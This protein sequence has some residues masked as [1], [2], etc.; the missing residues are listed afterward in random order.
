MRHMTEKDR[1]YIEFAL[2]KKIP[3]KEIAEDLGFSRVAIYEE[4]KKGKTV[5]RNSKTWNDEIVY[6]S[7]VG[8][9]KHDEAM[10]NTG[11]PCKLSPDAPELKEVIDLI[12]NQKYSPEAATYRTKQ[13]YVCVKTI[14][15]Y[16]HK[17]HLIGVTVNHLPY[18]V[19]KKKKKE[20]E[21][22]RPFK[23]RGKSIEQRPKE[24]L[25]RDT[26]GHWEMDTVY[27]SHDDLT[28]LLV[29]SE[30][31]SREE[32]VIQTKDR[33]ASSIIKSLNRLE[34][35]MGAPAFRNKFLT[36][37]CDNGMEFSDF[38]AIENS[39]LNKKN[40]TEL[41]FCHPHTSSERGTNEN[42]NRMIRRWIP[43]GDDIGLYTEQEISHIE[44]WINNYP[45]KIFGG[46][47]TNEFK[48]IHNLL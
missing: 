5:Q 11:R 48:A 14:Y 22:K 27:S 39:C 1:Q 2:K 45:R 46:L 8:Q 32:I 16:I 30:R 15:N 31:M 4:I 28:C 18:A 29:L 35:K 20:K 10:K 41:Y 38:E 13:K 17:K 26:Y 42:I 40:R 21:Q 24:V 37:T 3:I 19:E 7:D 6:L 33:T 12:V 43:K 44:E 34:K 23:I 25:Y 36:I 47:S 9:Q